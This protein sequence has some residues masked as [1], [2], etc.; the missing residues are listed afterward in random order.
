MCE[1]NDSIRVI[2]FDDMDRYAHKEGIATA[3]KMALIITTEMEFTHCYR[4]DTAQQYEIC[5]TAELD[6]QHKD[7]TIIR[8][9]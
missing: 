8:L 6:Q 9:R 4:N 3:D 2:S 1:D 5:N 7:D